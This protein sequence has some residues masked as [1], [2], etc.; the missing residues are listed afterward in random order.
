MKLDRYLTTCTKIKSKWI[1]Y[2]NVRPETIKLLEENIDG[3][4]LDIGL[5]DY[6][7]F[8]FKREV[9]DRGWGREEGLGERILSRLHTQQRAC[10]GAQSHNLEVMT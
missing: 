1:K 7:Y 2:L 10:L 8:F 6:Y 4:I 3:N 9:H 5:G